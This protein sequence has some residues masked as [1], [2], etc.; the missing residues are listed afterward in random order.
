MKIIDKYL[1]YEW[2]KWFLLCF[3]VL[4]SLLFLQFLNEENKLLD[5]GT[6][7]TTV[8]LF[9]IKALGY[10]TWLFPIICF[11]ST[12]LTFSFL[13][14][15][16]ELL[17]LVSSGFSSLSISL[18][19]VGL[20]L[21]CSILAWFFQDTGRI[22]EWYE[23]NF[24]QQ[25][26]SDDKAPSSFKM[27]L[28]KVNRTWFFDHYS[29]DTGFA[30]NIHL[31]CYDDRGNDLY[32]IS[33]RFGQ[34]TQSG[35][36]FNKGIFLGFSSAKG[37]PVINEQNQLTWDSVFVK[38]IRTPPTNI[39]LPKYQKEFTEILLPNIEDDP[40]PFALLRVR[41]KDLNY[42]DLTKL[43]KSYPD[44]NS[45]KLLPYRLRSAQL[46]WNAPACLFAVICALAIAIRREQYSVGFTIGLS[47]IWIIFFYV[48]RTFCEAFGKL[49]VFSDW[50]STGLPF[51]VIL[52]I[53]IG[54]LWR[55]R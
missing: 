35:W 6:F 45:P 28:K 4:Y 26:I 44:P 46:F 49:G 32:R 21:I 47:L 27:V 40:E 43:I 12:L 53:S 51:I 42:R 22:V 13:A 16:R 17:T 34:K 19:I 2:L 11:V 3:L 29:L 55:N 37:I 25:K 14:K 24:G 15:N 50:V 41:P 23:T 38:N 48:I 1:I 31:Y 54:I 9:L 36:K 20:A 10:L 5:N 33:S 18:P 30:K 7:L 8:N 52:L 39:N